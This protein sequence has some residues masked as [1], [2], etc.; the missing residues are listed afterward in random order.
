M[1]KYKNRDQIIRDIDKARAK[2]QC[3]KKIAQEHLDAEELLTGIASRL[4]ELKQH[5][6][7]ADAQF[8]KIKYLETRR[9]PALGNALAEWDTKLLPGIAPAPTSAP[10][11]PIEPQPAA[12]S[13]DGPQ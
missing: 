8:R 4:S 2:V 11:P 5:R 3:A 1:R 7:N 13:G 6:E 10:V 12:A 9:L